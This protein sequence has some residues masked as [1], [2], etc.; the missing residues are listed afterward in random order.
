MTYC[1][2]VATEDGFVFC[3]DSRTNAG[4]DVLSTYSKMHIYAFGDDRIIVLL[5]AGN[6]ATTQAVI[7]QIEADLES[8]EEY[9][10]SLK[11]CKK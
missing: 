11:T 2:V 8:E 6:L 1:V 7:S 4:S 10:A 9:E 3:S 5:S